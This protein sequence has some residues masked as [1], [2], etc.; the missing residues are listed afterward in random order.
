[1]NW[2]KALLCHCSSCMTRGGNTPDGL[3]CNTGL[4]VKFVSLPRIVWWALDMPMLHAICPCQHSNPHVHV[5]YVSLLKV[6][7]NSIHTA[8]LNT[9]Q[10]SWSLQIFKKDKSKAMELCTNTKHL[11]STYTKWPTNEAL[12]AMTLWNLRALH[13][14]FYKQNKNDHHHKLCLT[15]IKLLKVRCFGYV[16]NT[17]IQPYWH[18]YIVWPFLLWQKDMETQ[19]QIC[20]HWLSKSKHISNEN[21]L[22]AKKRQPEKNMILLIET[23]V[24]MQTPD[25]LL[26]NVQQK[27]GE[28]H[29]VYHTQ[30]SK[31]S[32]LV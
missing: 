5:P 6:R 2:G 20:E 23:N 26:Q 7:E 29:Q 28:C 3:E 27:H 30:K 16:A 4:P 10:P 8:L 1:M 11:Y 31:C 9:S 13:L 32:I 15:T 22:Q 19:A 25:S 12:V 24:T 17:D 18:T 14:F 21:D